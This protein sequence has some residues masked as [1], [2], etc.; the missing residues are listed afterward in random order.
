VLFLYLMNRKIQAGPDP[1]EEV[2]TVAVQSLP[3]T[4]REVFRKRPFES[5]PLPTD[6]APEVPAATSDSGEPAG[7]AA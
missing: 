3:D 1:L 4:F 2:E 5:G 7:G 6:D